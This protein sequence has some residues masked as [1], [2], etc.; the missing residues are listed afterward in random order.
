MSRFL[1]TLVPELSLIFE[2]G[3]FEDFL[4]NIFNF[5]NTFLFSHL[6]L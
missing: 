1:S 3:E 4:L 6:W 5:L 2:D